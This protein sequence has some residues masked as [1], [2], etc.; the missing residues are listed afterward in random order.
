MTFINR[1]AI[2]QGRKWDIRSNG[3]PRNLQYLNMISKSSD[4]GPAGGME[5]K[6]NRS[7]NRSHVSSPGPGGLKNFMLSAKVPR[8]EWR[9]NWGMPGHFLGRCFLTFLSPF[10]FL[11]LSLK[12]R[13][14]LYQ[15]LK[16]KQKTKK[17]KNKQTKRTQSNVKLQKQTTAWKPQETKHSELKHFKT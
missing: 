15:K 10:F 1:K 6:V 5:V 14:N 7:H 8:E 2:R 13:H 11:S 17:R 9:R 12:S 3:T 4:Q 16:N